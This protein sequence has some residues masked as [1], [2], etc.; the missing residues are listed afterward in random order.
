[1]VD[2]TVLER[3]PLEF[4]W[5]ELTNRCNLHCVHCYANSAPTATDDGAL[6]TNDYFRL[7]AESAR[8]GCRK[9]QFIGGEPTLNP[10]LPEFIRHARECG[11]EFVEV[12]T[13]GRHIPDTLIECFVKHRVNVAVSFYS[14]NS[15][16]HDA[17]TQVH[18]SH[19]ATVANLQ[20]MVQAALSVRVGIIQMPLNEKSISETMQFVSGLG[21]REYGVDRARKFG[22]AASSPSTTIDINELCGSCWQG[23]LC[24]HPDGQVSPCI[25]SREWTVGSIFETP[26]SD[27][28]QS[29]RLHRIRQ[30][31]YREVWLP[32]RE[33]SDPIESATAHGNCA[34]ECTPTC[35]PRCSPSCQPCWPF[36]KCRPQTGS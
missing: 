3:Q 10:S 12:Y 31:V 15:D 25:M 26:L 21:I 30:R 36:G 2:S 11:M 23:S 29:A 16:I 14:H 4:L 7:I 20:R 35:H 27:I 18:G 17:I 5:I 24:I 34:P 33:I 9:L 8:L 28:A 6:S 1:M 19:R 22:R 32:S 13:N